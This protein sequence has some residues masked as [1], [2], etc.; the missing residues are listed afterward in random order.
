MVLSAVP[1]LKRPRPVVFAVSLLLTWLVLALLAVGLRRGPIEKD[2]SQ[3]ANEAV[4]QSGATQVVVTVA[5]RAATLHGDFASAAAADAALR[6]A[7]VDGVGSARLGS[8]ALI[9]TR[10]AEPVVLSVDGGRLTVRATVPD[11][12]QRAALLNDVVDATGGRLTSEI[13]IDP[14][15]A[16]PALPALAGLVTALSRG[17]GTHTLTLVGGHLVLTGTVANESSRASLG[18]AVLTAG[19]T[20]ATRIDLDNQLVVATTAAPDAGSAAGA[21][22]GTS[23]AQGPGEAG[24]GLAAASSGH[25]VT[26]ASG[27]AALSDSDRAALDGIAVALRA[28]TFPALVAGHADGTG[29]ASV[30]QALSLGR[31]QA[32][33]GYLV[34]RGVLAGRLRAVGYGAN[35]PIA[36]NATRAGRA[37]NRRVEIVLDAGA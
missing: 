28:G 30:N 36:D 5:G 18:A 24:V 21:A 25:P 37:A 14:R 13:A 3:R 16:Q 35:R 31:A 11:R 17:P 20:G 8:D 9:A 19:R 15:A 32:V 1:Q 29:P 26:F 27:S 2:L 10:P 4:R 12:A 22:T 23:G 6:A 34:T 7:R 33:V